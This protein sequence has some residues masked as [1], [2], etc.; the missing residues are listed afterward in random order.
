MGPD[1]AP[2][3]TPQR[4]GQRWPLLVRNQ[5]DP[6]CGIEP[7]EGLPST[8]TAAIHHRAVLVARLSLRSPGTGRVLSRRGNFRN[9]TG[10]STPLAVAAENRET[11]SL[12]VV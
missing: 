6:S 5:S 2:A 9:T 10:M 3:G 12:N 8:V 7:T 11:M 4:F 1:V